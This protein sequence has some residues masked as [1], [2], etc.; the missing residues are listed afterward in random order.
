MALNVPKPSRF[1][2]TRWSLVGRA[3]A[4]DALTR[5][6]ALTEILVVYTPALRAFL[7]ETRRLPPPLADDLLQDFVVDKVLVRNLVQQA[8]QDRGKF[9]NFLLKALNNFVTTKL[10]REYATRAGAAGWDEAM[11]ARVAAPSHP[12]PFEQ[13]W[14]QQVVREALH[15]MEADCTT[16]GRTDLWDVFCLRVVHPLLHDTEPMEYAQ[17]VR[18]FHLR[19]PREAINLLA[20]AK[21]RFFTHVRTAVGRYVRDDAQ[22]DEELADLRAIVGR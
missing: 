18:R 8:D 11:L 6:Q 20:S 16:R 17:I 21:R 3:A 7:V 12:D 13:A 22:I 1:P 14:V 5:Q 2:H 4:S 10:Q 15:L 9:R 19:T